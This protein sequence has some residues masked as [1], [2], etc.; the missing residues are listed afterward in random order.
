MEEFWK[1]LKFW[2]KVKF[3]LSMIGLIFGIIFST[4]NWN[5]LEV[6]LIFTKK[7]MPLTIVLFFAFILGIAFANLLNYQRL[8]RKEKEQESHDDIENT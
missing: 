1:S 2:G 3:V 4:L 7:T 6:H 8:R 5:S